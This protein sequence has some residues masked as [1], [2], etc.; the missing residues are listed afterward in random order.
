MEPSTPT[1]LV[2]DE[3][4][5]WSALPDGRDGVGSFLSEGLAFTSSAFAAG[6]RLGVV[7]TSFCESIAVSDCFSLASSTVAGVG[8]TE[9]LGPD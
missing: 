9:E 4:G 5:P 6:M 1:A 2:L 8:A 7:S 3:T